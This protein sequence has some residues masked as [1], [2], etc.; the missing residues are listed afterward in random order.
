MLIFPIPQ[1]IPVLAQNG[2]LQYYIVFI[3]NES[4]SLNSARVESSMTTYAIRGLFPW[5]VYSVTLAGQNEAGLSPLSD[6]VKA[7]TLPIGWY[8]Q[9]VF[10][11]L[12]P[13]VSPACL[14]S[15]MPFSIEG[16]KKTSS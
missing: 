11:L 7:R 16:A 10:P 1:H 2:P 15:H 14:L 8:T 5:R 9:C 12:A 3:S 6:P 4:Q 13:A